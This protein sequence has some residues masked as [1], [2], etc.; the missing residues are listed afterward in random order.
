MLGS[1]V[2]S[3]WLCVR[4][5]WHHVLA[6]EL[7]IRFIKKINPNS[8]WDRKYEP[9]NATHGFS[10]MDSR[11]YQPNKIMSEHVFFVF[12][13]LDGMEPI[14][15]HG[16]W[17]LCTNQLLKKRPSSREWQVPKCALSTLDCYLWSFVEEKTIKFREMTLNVSDM[18]RKLVWMINHCNPPLWKFKFPESVSFL[19][20]W[21][22]EMPRE[23]DV[24]K[25]EIQK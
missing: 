12:C 24:G 20:A 15:K 14:G 9:L 7:L 10:K 2:V 13:W 19:I 8:I 18:V 23:I 4:S 16:G 1:H 17:L 21:S 25:S 11:R 6:R 22:L 3:C 5:R